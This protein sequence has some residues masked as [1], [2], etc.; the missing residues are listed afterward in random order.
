MRGFIGKMN[1]FSMSPYS[2]TR[3]QILLPNTNIFGQSVTIQ[4]NI[5]I[6]D[7]RNFF[8]IEKELDLNAKQLTLLSW[9]KYNI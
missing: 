1:F 9:F 8:F 2:Q 7:F 6:L 3:S 5:L 4:T